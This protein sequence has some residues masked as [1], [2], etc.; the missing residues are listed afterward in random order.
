MA[1]T[2]KPKA[3]AKPKTERITSTTVRENAKKDQSPKWDNC[4]EWTADQFYQHYH[5]AM[6]YYNLEF[7][8]KDLKPAVLRWMTVNDY[9]AADVA[10]FKKAKDW[11]S[12]S[13]MGA[14]AS[15]LLRGMPVQ[16]P[17]FNNGK[18]SAAWL[19]SAIK[20]AIAEGA[21][22]LA[23]E[24]KKEELAP[25]MMVVS[26]QERIRETSCKMTVEIEDAIEKF[27]SDPESFDPKAFKLL[28]LLKGKEVKAAHARVIK[29][30][31][32]RQLAELEELSSGQADDQLKEGFSNLTKKQI[33][34]L[35]DFFK[36]VRD[37]CDMLSQEAK[38]NRKPRTK[39]PIAKDKLISKLQFMKIHDML[40]LVSINPVDIIGVK[41][42]WVYNSK[43]RKL[44]KYMAAEYQTLGI[45]GTS[46]INFDVA[47]SVQKTLRKPDEKLKE[48]KTA[49]K[50]QLRKFLEDINATDTKLNGR[51][52]EEIILLKVS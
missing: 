23:A 18:N 28:N 32:A 36:E 46:I 40:K 24:E 35:I 26:I 50:I 6:K 52:N 14:L 47:A 30:L 27:I 42:L 15:C 33:R 49:G 10:T 20:T 4:E 43:T 1:T 31:Y 45:K 19:A 17:D 12:T 51:I 38:V 8:S 37:A 39:K 41:E 13:T 2:A 25:L 3:T 5:V 44:G 34:K 7:S 29:G 21:D 22:D 9:S 48:F 11:R 16:H